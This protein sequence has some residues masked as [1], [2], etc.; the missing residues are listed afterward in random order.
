PVMIHGDY[1][2]L[3]EENENLYVYTRSFDGKTLLVAANFSKETCELKLPEILNG[4]KL[5]VYN[6]SD[7]ANQLHNESNMRPYEVKVY[8]L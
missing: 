4:G 8:M 6:Y 1:Q 2:L 3:L 7:V 5:L